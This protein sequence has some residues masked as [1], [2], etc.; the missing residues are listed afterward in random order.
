MLGLSACSCHYNYMLSQRTS[1]H[2]GCPDI[3]KNCSSVWDI[4]FNNFIIQ[5]VLLGGSAHMPLSASRVASFGGQ[6]SGQT[7][8]DKIK[9]WS[10]AI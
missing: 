3:T 4:H 9:I 8:K 2:S 5:M 7:A 10:L 1:L 6:A